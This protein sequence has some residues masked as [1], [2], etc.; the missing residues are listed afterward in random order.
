M[1]QP[2][3]RPLLVGEAAA[4]AGAAAVDVVAALERPPPASDRDD[5]PEAQRRIDEISLA[6]GRAGY[7]LLLGSQALPDGEEDAEARCASFLREAIDGVATVA[8]DASLF[9][10]FSGVAW[11]ADVLDCALFRSREDPNEAIDQAVLSFLEAGAMREVD[12]ISGL[13][14]L[15][16]YALQ[17]LPRPAA[18]GCLERTVELLAARSRETR[19]GV[20]WFT[21]ADELPPGTRD[22][23]REG[24]FNLGMA[25]GCAGVVAFLAGA[26][27]AGVATDT[28]A[29]LLERSVA[30]L[31]AQEVPDAEGSVFPAVL[32]PDG[33]AEPSR[34]AWCYG[35]AGIASSIALAAAATGERAWRAEARRI[36]LGVARRPEELCGVRDACLCH[37]AAGLAHVLNRLAVD[38]EDDELAAS[39]RGWFARTLEMRAGGR[40]VGGFRTYRAGRDVEA[41]WIDHPGL[42][43]GSSGIALA[44][45]SAIGNEPPLWDAAFLLS[46]PRP[47]TEPRDAGRGEVPVGGSA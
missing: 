27:R 2:P 5:V 11:V 24:Y 40:G 13:V 7:A 18:V 9:M 45:L 34:T 39:A 43:A 26:A 4:R 1:T 14:G 29:A 33:H 22:V 28:A 20:A 42:L 36:A 41:R 44:L 12:L 25:H 38:L 32:G 3:W 15:G 8:M 10:G 47:E 19:E 17:R 35:D 21:P 23:F 30:W 16:V 6:R 37:G 31:L 46:H